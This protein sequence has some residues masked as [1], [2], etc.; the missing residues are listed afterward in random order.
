MPRYTWLI[1]DDMN[2]SNLESKMNG[3]VSLGVPYSPERISGAKQ[4]LLAQA[5]EVENNL[6]QDPE[7]VKNYGS[8]NIQNKEIVALIAYLQRLGTDIKANKTALK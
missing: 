1:K 3:L 5:K 2:A 4:E 7:F 8:S 6:R